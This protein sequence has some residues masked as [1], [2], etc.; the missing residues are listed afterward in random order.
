MINSDKKNNIS[1]VIYSNFIAGNKYTLKE[2][3]QI[4]KKIYTDFNITSTPKATDL[5]KYFLLERARIKIEDKL[6][7]GFRLKQ[8]NN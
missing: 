2:I 7:E 4:L 3:K 8:L 5:S 1:T 6:V